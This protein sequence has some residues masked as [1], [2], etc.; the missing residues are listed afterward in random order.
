MPKVKSYSAPWLSK[1]SSGHRLFEPSTD[2][3][4][5]RALSPGYSSK[6]KPLPGPRR[7]IATRGSEI[8]VAVGKEIRWADMVYQKGSYA[9]KQ[10]GRRGSQMP[11]A[12]R[13][14]SAMS[15][16]MDDEPEQAAGV[17]VRLLSLSL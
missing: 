17:R 13:E 10:Q 11:R 16:T 2:A 4:R 5:S 7:T 14:E 9:N 8:F 3:L 6:K 15:I 1:G 12:Q